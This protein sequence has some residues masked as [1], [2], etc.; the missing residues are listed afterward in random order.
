MFV[1]TLMIR[2]RLDGNVNLGEKRRSVNKLLGRVRSRFNAAAAEFGPEDDPAR[3]DLG[4]SVGGREPRVLNSVLQRLSDFVEDQADAEV[5][6][7]RLL[8]PAG[9]C[10]FLDDYGEDGLEKA[11]SE[12]FVGSGP[13]LGAA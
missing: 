3:A 8:C 2:L 10:S 5:T 11:A 7:W 12:V 9:R 4:F 13:P 6:A 1:A